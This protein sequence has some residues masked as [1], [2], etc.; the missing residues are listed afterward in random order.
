MVWRAWGL[1]RRSAGA[2]TERGQ[3]SGS[4]LSESSLL[5]LSLMTHTILLNLCPTIGA[6]KQQET[7]ERGERSEKK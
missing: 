2:T 3:R 1:K 6:Q 4:D 5:L 7:N